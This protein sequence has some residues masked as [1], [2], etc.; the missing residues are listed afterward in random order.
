MMLSQV[1]DIL[2]KGQALIFCGAGISIDPP[3]GLPNWHQ[4]RD[5][6]IRAIAQIDTTLVAYGETLISVDMLAEVGKRGMTPEVVASTIERNTSGYFECYSTVMNI[7]APNRNHRWLAKLAK[8]KLIRHI[9]TTN[10]DRFIEQALE[11]EKVAYTVCRTKEEFE[12]FDIASPAVGVFKLHGCLTAPDTIVATVEMEARGLSW[13]KSELLKRL[14]NEEEFLFWGYSGADLKLD[15]DY[16]KLITQKDTARGFVWNFYQQGDYRETP[17]P[18]VLD[19]QTRYG[20]RG[21][22][23]YGAFPGAFEGLIS[24]EQHPPTLTVTEAE[25]E[26]QNALRTAQM[27]ATLQVWATAK[28]SPIRACNIIADLLEQNALYEDALQCQNRRLTLARADGTPEWVALSLCGVA[29]LEINFGRRAEA[30]LCYQEAETLAN[31][32]NAFEVQWYVLQAIGNFYFIGSKYEQALA[33][34]RDA[35]ERLARLD[36]PSDKPSVTFELLYQEGRILLRQGKFEPALEKLQEALMYQRALGLVGEVVETLC[37][38]AS[39]HQQRG[40]DDAAMQA[41]EEAE[42]L[43]IRLG[44]KSGLVRPLVTQGMNEITHGNADAAYALLKRAETLARASGNQN[45]LASALGALGPLLSWQK[46]HDEAALYQEEAIRLLRAGSEQDNLAGALFTFAGMHQ[47]AGNQEAAVV[48]FD[49]AL[50]VWKAVGNF[51]SAAQ[52]A[53]M[54]GDAYLKDLN[55][56]EKA[57]VTFQE[58]L[59]W[60]LASGQSNSENAEQVLTSMAECQHRI[61]GEPAPTLL[62]LLSEAQQAVP[63]DGTS[64]VET[65]YKAFANNIWIDEDQYSLQGFCEKLEKDYG[66]EGGLNFV[67]LSL[68]GYG[69]KAAERGEGETAL[70]VYFAARKLAHVVGYLQMESVLANNIGLIYIEANNFKEGLRW[71]EM[72]VDT[73]R[74]VN[75][76][77]GLAQRLFN[78]GRLMDR[79]KQPQLALVYYLQ[80]ESASREARRDDTLLATLKA[81]AEAYKQT[82]DLRSAWQYYEAVEKIAEREGNLDDLT[83]AYMG[84]GKTA[85]ELG[86]SQTSVQYRLEALRIA[87]QLNDQSLKANLATLIANL[88]DVN[89]QQYEAAATYYEKAALYAEDVGDPTYAETMRQKAKDCRARLA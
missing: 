13:E 29:Q 30:Q 88:Y 73:A 38:I 89:L 83:L 32:S 37:E 17:N 66:R 72:A 87:D 54:L 7:G 25:R 70:Y 53:Q 49:E 26:A 9:A 40:Q 67:L 75:D 27:Q 84:K 86:E 63:S 79:M 52:A 4:L 28:V 64:R 1:A 20:E 43:T 46:R 11:D 81:T 85:R 15:L 19:L 51:S 36:K 60:L 18:Y 61:S 50:Q 78:L 44:D 58:S 22:I 80:A 6:T 48:C 76:I 2:T 74:Q 16:L 71:Y 14:L 42:R 23:T 8:A 55:Q 3:A 21:Q 41:I 62:S 5:D 12:G 39:L 65:A 57:L 33:C 68:L 34:Y 10:W 69:D 47:V 31:Q 59:T 35:E 45:L 24:T 77:F 82:K 56:P